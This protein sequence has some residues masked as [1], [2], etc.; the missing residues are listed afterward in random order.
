MAMWT[1]VNKRK[2]A[3]QLDLPV[4]KAPTECLFKCHL[5]AHKFRKSNLQLL[6]RKVADHPTQTSDVSPVTKL[7]IHLFFAQWVRGKEAKDRE[8][9]Q[10]G[11]TQEDGTT[12]VEEKV[13]RARAKAKDRGEKEKERV[14]STQLMGGAVTTM[15]TGG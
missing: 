14:E 3:H 2:R 10:V 13:G 6:P 7:V 12:Q 15:R 8:V 5:G 11:T 1:T 9:R 4:H